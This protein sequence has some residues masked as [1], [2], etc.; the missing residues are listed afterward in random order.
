MKILRFLRSWLRRR[1]GRVVIEDDDLPDQMWV[2]VDKIRVAVQ[3]VEDGQQASYHGFI[4]G[5]PEEE[6]RGLYFDDLEDEN[7]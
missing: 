1:F 2:P 3:L 7:V 4:N 6:W 5:M